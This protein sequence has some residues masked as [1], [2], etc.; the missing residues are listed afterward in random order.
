MS[1]LQQRGPGI[2]KAG[3]ALHALVHR[4][5][6]GNWVMSWPHGYAY[7]FWTDRM[8]AESAAERAT[9]LLS[10]HG[11]LDPDLIDDGLRAAGVLARARTRRRLRHRATA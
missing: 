4:D 11:S 1:E 10:F 9:E 6:I 2:V 7:D 5:P 3:W 8:A